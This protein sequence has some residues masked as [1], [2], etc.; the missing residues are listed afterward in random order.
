MNRVAPWRRAEGAAGRA[1]VSAPIACIRVAP[2]KLCTGGRG[3]SVGSSSA[4]RAGQPLA[5]VG[6]LPLQRLAPRASSRCQTAKSAYWTASSGSGMPAGDR[7][8]ERDDLLARSRRATSR[9]PRCGGRRAA[10]RAPRAPG[11]AA[12]RAAAGPR[13]RSNGRATSWSARRRASARRAASGSAAR[14]TSGSV[15]AAG[16]RDHLHRPVPVA[17]TIGGAQ[18][19]VAPHHLAERRAPAP[20]VERSPWAARASGML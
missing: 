2:R 5:P 6:E 15:Q 14:S 18:R 20:A 10:A 17:P 19:L 9:R 8:I 1:V 16:G 3:R 7:R 12:R 13:S 11:G 4:R